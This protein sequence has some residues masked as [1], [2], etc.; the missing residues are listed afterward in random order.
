[1]K[2]KN[3]RADFLAC[4]CHSWHYSWHVM[5]AEKNVQRG[6]KGKVRARQTF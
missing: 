5:L 4:Y 2:Q 6:S 3:K 1:M